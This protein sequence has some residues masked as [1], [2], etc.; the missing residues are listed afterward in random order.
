MLNLAL[1]LFLQWKSVLLGTTTEGELL[2]LSVGHVGYVIPRRLGFGPRLVYVGFVVDIVAL[3]Q[4]FLQAFR[5]LPANYH[6]Q[7]S[8]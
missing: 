8:W 1:F 6:S 4:V 3:R 5:F 2:K 7:S